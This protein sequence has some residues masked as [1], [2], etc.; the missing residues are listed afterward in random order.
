ML[1]GMTGCDRQT[2]RQI[3]NEV[4]SW[5]RVSWFYIN[6]IQRDATLCRCLFTAKLLYMFRMSIAPIIRSISNCKS[7]FWYSS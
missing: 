5:F 1:G 7:R 6:K 2:E 4:Y 3:A